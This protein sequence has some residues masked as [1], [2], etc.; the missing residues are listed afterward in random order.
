MKKHRVWLTNQIPYCSTDESYL[1]NGYLDTSIDWIPGMKDI[2]LKDLSSF[3][4]TVDGD[5]LFLNN[6]KMVAEKSLR[7]QGLI[8]NTFDF[9]ETDVLKALTC[10]FNKVY[11]IGPLLQ[12]LSHI[13]I[14]HCI[15]MS[16]NLWEEDRG[17]MEWLNSQ[18]PHSVI[19]VSFG[20]IT[21]VS[22]K[23]LI[24]FAW[25]LANS[26]HPILWVIRPDLVHGGRAILPEDFIEETK[27]RIYLASWCSQE[28]VLSHTSIGGFLT[29][30][31]W[32]STLESICCGVPMICWPGY[33]EQYTN[34]RYVCKEWGMGMQIDEDV[35]R[36][37]VCCMVK[38]MMEGERGQEMRKNALKWKDRA[39][40]A[41]KQGG[42][43]YENAERLIEDLN[44]MKM[45]PLDLKVNVL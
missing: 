43:S 21:T 39:K 36:E 19:Y 7:A 32:N 28:E 33:A 3:I 2:R 29:H 4:R 35:E 23:Q 40:E 42:S 41:T 37:Q 22:T 26:N 11:T 13:T 25:G 31:G 12:L 6:E 45:D 5:D 34:A 16:L 14:S 10:M 44:R 24:E 30:C 20:S 15:S 9:L 1:T 17:Y 27:G 38:E 18:K 8:L